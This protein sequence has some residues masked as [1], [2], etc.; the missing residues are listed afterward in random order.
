MRDR[1]WA[2]AAW[3]S[4]ANDFHEMEWGDSPGFMVV[5]K[6]RILAVIPVP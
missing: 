2:R 4:S 3:R 6:G 1:P 5:T